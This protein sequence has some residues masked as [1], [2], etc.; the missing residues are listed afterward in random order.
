MKSIVF[1][2]YGEQ[3]MSERKIPH[4]LPRKYAESSEHYIPEIKKE[5]QRQNSIL[6]LNIVMILLIAYSLFLVYQAIHH[7]HMASLSVVPLGILQDSQMLLACFRNLALMSLYKFAYFVPVG[8]M[9]VF[10]ISCLLS[11]FSLFVISLFGILLA[12]ALTVLVQSIAYDWSWDL[13]A[14]VGLI[15]PVLGCLFGTWIGT[16]WLRGRRACLWFV[17]K[18][19]IL[20]LL[21]VFCTGIIMKLS[22]QEKPLSFEPAQIASSDKRRLGQLL[23]SKNPRD[24]IEGQTDTLRLT[25]DDINMLLSWGL[26]L[27]SPN[28]KARVE[29]GPD[30]ASL[31]ASI[32]IPGGSRKTGY[33]NLKVTGV[34]VIKER[35]L[36]LNMQRLQLG[37]IEMPRWIIR[38]LSLVLISMLD[39]DQ[40]SKPFLDATQAITIAQ[41]SIE[42]TYGPLFLNTKRY[43]E[44]LFGSANAG[45]EVL[46]STRAQVENLLAFISRSP[47]TQPDFGECFETVFSLARERSID[48]DP[49]IENR[50][51]IFALGMLLGHPRVEEFL[52]PVHAGR[53][54]YAARRAL[55]DVKLRGR[56]DWTKHFCV[57]A[58]ITLLSDEVMSHAASVLKED[59]DAN[60]T[61]S[62]FSFSD[63][64]MGQAGTKFA[65]LATQNEKSARAMQERIVNGF[66]VE[67]FVPPAADLPEGIT[68]AELQSRYGGVGG[69]GYNRLAE[70]I[71]RRISFCA[72]YLRLQ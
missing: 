69:E 22:V 28:R 10:L 52:G 3:N 18:V 68:D 57:A 29:L 27:G 44:Q 39:N 72:A 20:I 59:L 67:D 66:R 2:I 64:L 11:R 4:I 55:S 13:A 21:A 47:D 63:L 56:S 34:P 17:P 58:A 30:I 23:R 41:D 9:A 70:E 54:K 5:P 26:S 50:A 62:G 49:V 38:I 71:E 6:R 33:L 43:R 25:Q 16:T 31:A 60:R 45:E 7:R 32:G 46:A 14:V 37:N 61:G 1:S 65:I 53:D 24:L 40:R 35:A 12:S 8:F 36:S 48:G 15:I 51:G 19:V 42:V